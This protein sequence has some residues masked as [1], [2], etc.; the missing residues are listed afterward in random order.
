MAAKMTDRSQGTRCGVF[1]LPTNL[2]VANLYAVL[3]VQKVLSEEADLNCYL[4]PGKNATDLAKLRANAEKSSNRHGSFLMPFAFG[5]AP[6]LQVFGTD[7][8]VVASSRAVQIPL[9]RFSGGERQVI[10]HI[11]VMLYPR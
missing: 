9:F 6:L 4:K 10:D 2:S 3:V 5:V 1:P 7:N 8:P 11:M